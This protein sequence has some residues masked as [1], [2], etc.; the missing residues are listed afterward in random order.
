MVVVGH[1]L[2]VAEVTAE[3]EVARQ[4]SGAKA[5]EVPDQWSGTSLRGGDRM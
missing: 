4:P 3:A 2:V 5:E 1:P